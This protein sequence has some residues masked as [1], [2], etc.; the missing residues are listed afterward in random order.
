MPRAL[1]AAG[2]GRALLAFHS[3]LVKRRSGDTYIGALDVLFM[4]GLSK[5]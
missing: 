5:R 4:D 2:Y 3:A 1:T